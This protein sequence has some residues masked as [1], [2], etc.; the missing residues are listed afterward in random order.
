MVTGDNKLTARAIAKECGVI[1]VGN[2]NSVV[3]EGSEFILA[4][5]GVICKKC[6]VQVCDCPRDSKTAKKL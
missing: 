6:R 2:E 1:E 5:G 3:M 4:I